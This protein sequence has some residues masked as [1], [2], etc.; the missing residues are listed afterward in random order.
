MFV[1]ALDMRMYCSTWEMRLGALQE[2]HSIPGVTR[3]HDSNDDSDTD[4][5][6]DGPPVARD[7]MPICQRGISLCLELPTLVSDITS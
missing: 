2:K 5:Q 1:F 7:D 6:K 3:S 4:A